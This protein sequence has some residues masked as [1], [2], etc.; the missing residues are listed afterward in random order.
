[1]AEPDSFRFPVLLGRRLC[2]LRK[3]A[4]LSQEALARVM[5]RQGR[6][7][8]SFVC[9]LEQ[10][11]RAFPTLAL[12]ADYLRACRASFADIRDILD[13]YTSRPRVRQAQARAAVEE[14]TA[15]L[16]P[17][18]RREVRDWVNGRLLDTRVGDRSKPERRRKEVDAA[19]RV[20]TLRR[21]YGNR[22]RRQQLEDAMYEVLVK[23]GAGLSVPE[24]ARAC[25]HGR[26]VFA[27]LLKSRD[28]ERR[29]ERLLAK[30][31]GPAREPG[32][33]SRGRALMEQAAL[34]VYGWLERAGK[35]DWLPPETGFGP[36]AA[37]LR[38]FR[39]VRA[40]QRLAEEEA[41]RERR[42]LEL[43]NTCRTAVWFDINREFQFEGRST[44]YRLP[45][46]PWVAGLFEVVMTTEPGAERDRRLAELAAKH[47]KLDRVAE[48]QGPAVTRAEGLKRW[49][50]ERT[51]G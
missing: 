50:A 36:E 3:K 23:E 13:A 26:R 47:P 4:G 19:R 43:R 37:N 12:V 44:E 11:K 39:T 51:R 2:S 24:R 15:A 45:Y 40:E 9:R 25:E 38:V 34:G 8:G 6:N 18:E 22:W 1:M 14:F 33:T 42:K 30:E 5:G 21:M 46:E 20:L 49:L 16:P 35:L 29:R 27:I 31:H 10:G 32:E 28:D 17:A 48:L 7:A 41:A